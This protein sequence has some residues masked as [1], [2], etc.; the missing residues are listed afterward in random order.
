MNHIIKLTTFLF[1]ITLFQVSYAQQDEIIGDDEPV[2]HAVK[3]P[4]YENA[5]IQLNGKDFALSDE[6]NITAGKKY[7]IDVTQLLPNSVVILKLQKTGV[8]VDQKKFY[9]NEEG[10]LNL[11]TTLPK[12]KLQASAVIIYTPSNGKVIER[13]IKVKLS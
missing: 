5:R 4:K 11:E 8:R 13:K 7:Q 9:A 10:E 12:Q 6:I 3:G 2:T 1:L